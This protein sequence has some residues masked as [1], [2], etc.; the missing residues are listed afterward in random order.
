MGG[1]RSVKV[2]F[3]SSLQIMMEGEAYLAHNPQECFHPPACEAPGRG[4]LKQ[5]GAEGHGDRVRKGECR[6]RLHCGE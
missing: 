3:E 5:D 2:K 4:G 6:N 1:A